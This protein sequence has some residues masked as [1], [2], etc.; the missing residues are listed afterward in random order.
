[1]LAFEQA[2]ADEFAVEFDVLPLEAVTDDAYAEVA[3]S[4]PRIFGCPCMPAR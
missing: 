1:M 2:H 3:P 4:S